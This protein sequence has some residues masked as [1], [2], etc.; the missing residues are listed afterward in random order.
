MSD[1]TVEFG[2]LDPEDAYDAEDPFEVRLAV[3]ERV[4]TDLREK[5]SDGRFEVRRTDILRVL[6]NFLNQGTE[7]HQ[8]LQELRDELEAM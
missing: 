8:R 3:I 2:D 1:V 5:R 6:G 4:V 7:H